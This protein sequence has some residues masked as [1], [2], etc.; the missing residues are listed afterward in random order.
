MRKVVLCTI[1]IEL[2]GKDL[3]VESYLF[4]ERHKDAFRQMWKEQ[5][6]SLKLKYYVQRVQ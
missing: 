2:F 4:F 6:C 3:T 5:V 1:D